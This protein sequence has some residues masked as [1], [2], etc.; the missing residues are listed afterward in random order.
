MK[1]LLVL[2]AG[3]GTGTLCAE[4]LVVHE[5]GTFTVLQNEKGESLS[6]INIDDEPVPDFVHRVG[7]LIRASGVP[8]VAGKAPL[9][10]CHPDVV[11]R[12]ETPVIYFY[13]PKGK[14]VVVD[15]EVAFPGGW[16][17]EYFP[18][19]VAVAPGLEKGRIDREAAG[20]LAW[21]G[22]IVGGRADGPLTDSHVWLAPREVDAASVRTPQGETE[23]YLFYRGVANREAPVRISR[24]GD[25][26]KMTGETRVGW[27]ADFRS[28]G[29]MAFVKAGAEMPATLSGHS[30]ENLVLLRNEMREELIAE[31]L[32]PKEAEAMLKAWE[33]S[34]FRSR[35][36]R[37]FYM[38]PR[39]WTDRHLPLKISG[40]T[41]I[42]RAM[43][44]RIELVT[45]EQRATLQ[46]LVK[47]PSLRPDDLPG[48]YFLLGRFAN[49]LLMDEHRR[50][51][52]EG[53]RRWVEM[54]R[55]GG[56]NRL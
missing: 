16:I 44:G 25:S 41:E 33:D 6:G 53:T 7:W 48:G 30:K 36:L 47:M 18:D 49:A 45:P 17:S 32:F 24:H 12:L 2:L 26:L 46:R 13:P 5:W 8:V 34:Y 51:E 27:L 50:H 37:V 21:K 39:E 10:T 4:P 55:L 31:G 20:T 14:E 42:V 3:L 1:R 23:R 9:P 15:V 28:D 52:T 19:A 56:E 40:E 22:L 38:V 35:G 11:M 43:I 54:L 29:T